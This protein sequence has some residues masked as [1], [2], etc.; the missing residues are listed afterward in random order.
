[1]YAPLVSV[2]TPTFRHEA[3][4]ESCLRSVLAQTYPTWELI[5][6]DD[7]SPDR[8]V[9][10]VAQ[11]AAGDDRIRLVRHHSNSG[12]ARLSDTYNEA[13]A[14]CRGQLVAVLEGDDAWAPAKLALQV[15]VFQDD[16]VVL[17]YGDYDQV[18]TDGVLIGRHGVLDAVGP[19]RSDLRQNLQFFS[20]LR[21]FGSNTVMA[22][23]DAL[24]QI[25]GF[26]SGG[27]P[28]VD[29]PTWLGLVPTGDFVRIPSV[30]GSWRRHPGSVYYASEHRTIDGLE[31][32]FL[33]YLQV[34]R[35]MLLGLGVGSAELAG[36][37]R[38]AVVAAQKRR[39]SKSYYEG[40]YHL[41]FGE[42][43]KAIGPFC[44]AI[45]DPGTAPR[46]RLGA[47]AGMLAA[48]TSPRLVPYLG[49]LTRAIRSP[50]GA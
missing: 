50:K 40:K 17:S 30:L 27:L 3:F 1:M 37:A 21:S 47:L 49:R 38:N 2:I 36:L 32:Y 13:L 5:A 29:Y 20:T 48:A 16:R 42:R 41:L 9:E 12:V 11:L 6:V 28:L 31:Q 7:A 43:L 33:S 8:T 44:R 22:R 14:Q 24:L 34:E 4:I 45:V 10:I 15:P 46:H 19:L 25:G 26:R 39:S 18:T 23:M 35:E